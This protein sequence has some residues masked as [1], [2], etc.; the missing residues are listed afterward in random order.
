MRC[1]DV[2]DG[3]YRLAMRM[4]AWHA[5]YRRWTRAVRV[6]YAPVLAFLRGSAGSLD[7]APACRRLAEETSR[8]LAEP[9][10]FR[11]PDER[12]SHPLLR[13]FTSLRDLGLACSR[14]QDAV[15]RAEA[16]NAQ[17]YLARAAEVLHG[18]GLRP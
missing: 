12:L 7:P 11:S 14:H 15:A 6:A 5:D 10:R 13:A 1:G 3:K 4:R 2:L 8:A 18:Y 16:D 17:G 9:E